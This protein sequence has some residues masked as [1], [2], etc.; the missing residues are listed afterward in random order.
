MTV[1]IYA[2][3]ANVLCCLVVHGSKEVYRVL[4]VVVELPNCPSDLAVV[5]R[6][7]LAINRNDTRRV[8]EL[9]TEIMLDLLTVFFLIVSNPKYEIFIL[10]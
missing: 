1:I 7:L 4:D 3:F 6:T 2:L 8:P 5:F 9:V 10:F